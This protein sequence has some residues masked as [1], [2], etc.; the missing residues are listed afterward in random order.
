[1]SRP[2]RQVPTHYLRPNHTSWTPPA[3]ISFDTE[4]FTT[5]D[6]DDEILNLRLWCARFSDRRAPKGVKP[7]ESR[8]TGI[9]GSDL[10][11]TIHGWTRNR[12]TVW[13]YAHNLGF[14]L[15]TS[16]MV[17][18]LMQLGWG[19]TEFAV[20][21][22]APFVRM[23]QAEHSLTLSDSWSWFGVPLERVAEELGTRK[24][25]LPKNDDSYEAWL[26]RCTKDVDILHEAM[27][28]LMGWWDH[29]DLGKWN[30]T[31]SASGWNA[32]RHIPSPERILIRPDDSECDHDRR[33][34]YGGRRSV[35]QTGHYSYGHYSEIDIEK[36]YTVA[37]RDLP[38]PIG[39]QARF[40]SLPIDHKWL[41]CDRWGVI[42]ECVI[43]T[44]TACV[45]CRVGNSVWYPVGKFR[46]VLAGPDIREARIHNRLLWVGPGWLHRLSY[47]LQPWASWCIESQNDQTGRTPGV[48][49]LVHRSWGRTAV[50]K[51]AQR[52]FEV[53]HLGPSPNSGWNYEDAWHHEGNTPAGIVDFGGE[54]YQ[55]AAVNQADNAYPAILAFVESHVRVALG[56]A[57]TIIGDSDMVMCDTDGLI[58]TAD[59][60]SKLPEVNQAVAPFHLREKQHYRRVKVTGP[61]HLE[62]DAIKRRAGI[63]ATAIPI[64]GGKLKANTWPKLAWQLANGR[65]G[66][67]VRPAQTYRLAATYAPGWV[68]EDG[69]VV[70][71]EL[72]L[73]DAGG[74]EVVPW[75]ETRYQAQ[76]ARLAAFQNRHLERYRRDENQ[77]RS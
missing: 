43:S 10:A 35:W 26:E 50:G 75:P 1:M 52:G 31:G 45:P 44:D 3:L 47:P 36:A 5:R 20:N 56:R 34:I 15:C 8:D 66:A 30:I 71:L 37:C 62:L 77:P 59:G 39:R 19:V 72:R 46:T 64:E 74:N 41:D 67:Y 24:Q 7:L 28:A 4:T 69:T 40:T 53:V 57:I 54:R 9:I 42:A 51:W 13:A 55:V 76:G 25:P 73:D 2:M 23:R 21:S 70:P 60:A 6:G 61:Q 48:A 29:E 17:E 68:L 65:Q 38:L 16:N 12:R 22:S 33:A 18:N 27:L 11:A 63:P 14:D 49:K 58:C 32:M